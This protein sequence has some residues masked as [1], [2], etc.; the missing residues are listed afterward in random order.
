MTSSEFRKRLGQLQEVIMRGLA[1]YAVWSRLR[2]HDQGR[3]SWSI[4]E[5]NELLG[6]WRGFFTP[7]SLAL[8]DMALMQFA[9]AF[10]T[11][12]RTASLPVLLS[13]A[14]QDGR[15]IPRGAPPE[16]AAVSAKVQRS[17]ATLATLKQLRNQQLAHVDANPGWISPL[18]SQK[19]ESLAEDVKS[20]FNFLSTA[21]DGRFFSW[22]PLLRQTDEQ[23]TEILR[24]LLEEMGRKQKE[25][26][27]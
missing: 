23:T 12:S 20:A 7:V 16:L 1:Y 22:N 18:K 27:E 9:K 21:H 2:L 6:R 19:I 13:A 10:D 11:D 25:H 15:L 8:M 24:V 14:K 4:E 5:Q 26:E 3:V 17:S